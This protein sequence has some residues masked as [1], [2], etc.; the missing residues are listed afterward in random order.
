MILGDSLVKDIKGWELSDESSKVVSKHFSGANT[1]DMKPYL[2]PTKSRNPENIVLHCSTKDLRKENSSNEISND[3]IEVAL[4]CKS[5]NSN[6]LVSGIIPR[7]DKLSAK[8]IEVNRNLKNKCRKR[9]IYLISRG[10]S[11]AAA[12]SKMA[13]FVII[14]NGYQPLTIITKRSILDAAAALDPPLISNSNINPKYDCNKSGLH[15]NWKGTNKLVENF[16]FA[17]S[18]FDNSHK[19]QVSNINFYKNKLG[20]SESQKCIGRIDSQAEAFKTCET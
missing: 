5:D 4:L 2:L 6:V 19:A 16:L 7:S 8:A 9:N 3:I 12:T 14:V 1:T 20:S 10:G 15:L 11:R 17:L 13:C 18:K